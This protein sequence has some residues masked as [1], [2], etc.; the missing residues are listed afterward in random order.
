MVIKTHLWEFHEKE[1]GA[2]MGEFGG[3]EVPMLYTSSMEEHNIVRTAV[4]IFD[5]AHMGRIKLTGPDVL[6]FLQKLYP[7]DMSKTKEY[8]MSGPTLALNEYA[9]VKD[10]EMAY[11]VSDEEWFVIANAPYREKMLKYY[12]E[13]IKKYGFKVQVEDLTLK[14]AMIAV[15]GPKVEEVFEKVGAGWANDLHTLEFRMNEEIA[16]QKV[17]LISRSGWTGEDGFEI[18]AEPKAM[19][20]IYRALLKAGAKPVGIICRD[21]LRI[22]MGFV[23]GGDEY[24]E[25]PTKFP[26]ACCLRYG[27]GAIDWN[28]RGYIGEEA[29]RACRR[30]GCRWIRVGIRMK[31]KHARAIL[32]HGYTVYV[33]DQPVGWITSGTY[34]PYLRRSVGQAYIDARYALFGDTVEVEIRGKRYEGRIFDFPLIPGRPVVK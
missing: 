22:E 27:L 9:R 11:K 12:D 14:L 31:K 25:D 24:G 23:L 32:R 34:S 28:K 16:G 1:L 2:T 8:W 5:V 21:T 3:W 30:E 4:G 6:P 10:D 18:W 15:Q 13:V 20:E 29:L 17:Y 19:V 26:P 33:E 7:K